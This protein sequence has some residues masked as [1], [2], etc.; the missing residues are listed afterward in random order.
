M[1]FSMKIVIRR[2]F[3]ER[4]VF[5]GRTEKDIELKNKR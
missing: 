4:Y 5:S 3:Q 1:T 2:I